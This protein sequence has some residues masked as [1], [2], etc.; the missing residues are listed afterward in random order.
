M[1][2]I[3]PLKSEILRVAFPFDVPVFYSADDM[4]LV[5]RSELQL[6]LVTPIGVRILEQEVQPSCSRLNSFPVA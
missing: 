1:S 5:S 6:H 4:C 3:V 2:G